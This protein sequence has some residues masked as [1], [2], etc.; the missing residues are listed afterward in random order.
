MLERWQL[1]YDEERLGVTD[2]DHASCF[3][4]FG[5]VIGYFRISL[6]VRSD[7]EMLCIRDAPCLILIR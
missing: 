2:Y 3:A 4:R 7:D 1:I 6:A 5:I